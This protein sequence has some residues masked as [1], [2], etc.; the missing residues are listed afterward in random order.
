[1]PVELRKLKTFDK[2]DIPRHRKIKD[3]KA[4]NPQSSQMSEELEALDKRTDIPW[5]MLGLMRGRIIQSY[6]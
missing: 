2:T 5:H 6:L 4:K 1:M 3:P